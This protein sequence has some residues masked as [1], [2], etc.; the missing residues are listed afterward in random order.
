MSKKVGLWAHFDRLI[1]F[2]GREDRASFWPYAALVYGIMTVGTV[3][4]MILLMRSL[5]F[6]SDQVAPA[7]PDF[8][9]LIDGMMI[10]SVIAVLLYA[11]AAVRRLHDAGLS[12]LWGLMPLP[13]LIF[14]MVKLRS[15]FTSFGVG[16]GAMDAFY[17]I[18]SSNMIYIL[19]VI[20]LIVL[21]CRRSDPR[22]NRYDNGSSSG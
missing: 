3:I 2:K 21:L 15:A 6:S 19:T 10:T 9:A 14:S 11:A 18:F 17:L 7:M 22:P 12:G 8:G 13:F 20:A 5:T 1:D 4:V 16:P